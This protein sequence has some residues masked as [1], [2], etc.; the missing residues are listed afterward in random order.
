MTHQFGDLYFTSSLSLYPQP[1]TE[2]K[3]K[4]EKE[5]ELLQSFYNHLHMVVLSYAGEI[6]LFSHSIS[7]ELV[8]VP[9]YDSYNLY[10]IIFTC[11]FH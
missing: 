8:E 9:N 2:K 3:E 7:Q 6:K 4:N 10:N 11:I 5:K 1:P